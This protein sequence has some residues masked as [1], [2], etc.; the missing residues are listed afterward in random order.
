LRTGPQKAADFKGDGGGVQHFLQRTGSPTPGRVGPTLANP[1]AAPGRGPASCLQVRP[2]ASRVGPKFLGSGR[3][4]P[5]TAFGVGL[6]P[7]EAAGKGPRRPSVSASTLGK[8][9]AKAPDGLRCRP[10][11]LGSGR[12]R[13]P[14]A[15]GVGLNPWEAAGKGPRRPSVSAST[16]GKRSAKAPDGLPYRPQLLRRSSVSAPTFANRPAKGRRF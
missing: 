13:P 4:R 6:N 5:P 14:T 15:F 2:T 8:R 11:P 7:W 12:Q 3:Q 16:L 9:S 10:Q 1:R